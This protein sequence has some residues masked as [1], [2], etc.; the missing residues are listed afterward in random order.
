M[1]ALLDD[2]L[3]PE[4]FR[5]ALGHDKP[6]IDYAL[7]KTGHGAYIH[8]FD[9]LLAEDVLG[10]REAAREYRQAIARAKGPAK[11]IPRGDGTTYEQKFFSQIWDA[12]FD[13]TD[14]G[15]INNADALGELLVNYLGFLG[16]ARP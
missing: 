3:E 7:S 14:P 12:V 6:A 15:A 11:V 8:M 4:T 16:K 9:E 5:D 2:G 10:G 13:S 1:P